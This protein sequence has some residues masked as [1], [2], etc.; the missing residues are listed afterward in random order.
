MWGLA[1]N[2]DATR[3]AEKREGS[4]SQWKPAQDKTGRTRL[5]PKEFGNPSRTAQDRRNAKGL[6]SGPRKG[7]KG[8]MKRRK[9]LAAMKK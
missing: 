4:V 3:G 9:G 6:L 8:G 7:M 2:K 5:V 1:A